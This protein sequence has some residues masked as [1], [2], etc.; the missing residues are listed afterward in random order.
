MDDQQKRVNDQ[1]RRVGDQSRERVG[2]QSKARVGD[3]E[4]NLDLERDLKTHRNHEKL[5][6]VG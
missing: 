2:D 3:Q 1:Q 6:K 5:S 4:C